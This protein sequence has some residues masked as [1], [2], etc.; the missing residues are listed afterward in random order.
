MVRVKLGLRLQ[1]DKTNH[2]ILHLI[3][4]IRAK[5]DQ[6]YNSKSWYPQMIRGKYCR[7]PAGHRHG[8]R[9]PGRNPR[10][11]ILVLIKPLELHQAKKQQRLPM[12]RENILANSVTDRRTICRIYKEFKLNNITIQLTKVQRTWTNFLQKNEMQTAN[13]WKNFQAHQA[14]GKCK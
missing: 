1:T 3:K 4:N 9:L 11:P 2:Q 8:Q 14:S 6:E 10:S 5:M 13:T 7:Q 12:E